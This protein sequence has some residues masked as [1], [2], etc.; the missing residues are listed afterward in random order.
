MLDSY[1]P[2]PKRR[3]AQPKRKAGDKRYKRSSRCW[4]NG[5]PLESKRARRFDSCCSS[6][7]IWAVHSDRTDRRYRLAQFVGLKKKSD[8]WLLSDATSLLATRQT[9][10]LTRL[11]LARRGRP[12]NES[13]YLASEL[14]VQLFEK[15]AVLKQNGRK[16]DRLR[17]VS[18]L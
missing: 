3:P 4:S 12:S 14:G 2:A 13:F 7:E 18:K 11:S 10:T 1:F 8:L 6:A 9:K 5:S 15:G 16:V 17:P